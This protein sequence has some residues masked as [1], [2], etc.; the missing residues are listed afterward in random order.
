MI[1]FT[2]SPADHPTYQITCKRYLIMLKAGTNSRQCL[3]TSRIQRFYKEMYSLFFFNDPILCFIRSHLMLSKIKSNHH[4]KSEI[5]VKTS[6][7]NWYSKLIQ[8]RQICHQMKEI[9]R[10]FS[11]IFVILLSKPNKKELIHSQL[12][13]NLLATFIKF[14]MLVLLIICKNGASQK[15]LKIKLKYFTT[16]KIST[17]FQP[18]IHLNIRNGSL[19]F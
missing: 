16:T 10:I 9:I 15:D 5:Q 17:R 1:T 7:K 14:I 19:T 6:L 11:Q 18:L 8:T 2:D 4:N 13:N 12:V 3:E